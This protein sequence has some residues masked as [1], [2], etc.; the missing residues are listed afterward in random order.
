M[1]E[2]KPAAGR[3]NS[4][5]RS[6]GL[7][8][9]GVVSLLAAYQWWRGRVGLAEGL[10]LVGLAL[11]TAALVR[12]RVLVRLAD[13]WFRFAHLLGYINTRVLLTVMFFVLLAPIGLLW[14]VVGRDPLGR[15]RASWPGW[16]PYPARYRDRMHYRRM[17]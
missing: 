7:S 4:R 13:V 9:G 5:E 14:R 16:S 17:F 2:R 11:I 3:A 12:P 15:R 6:F 10:I 8:V 1:P